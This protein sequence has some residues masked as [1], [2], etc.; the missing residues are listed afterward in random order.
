MIELMPSPTIPKAWVAP[1][2]IRDDDIGGVQVGPEAGRGLADDVRCVF[3]RAS[4]RSAADCGGCDAGA[5]SYGLQKAPAVERSP[6][7]DIRVH[8]PP[9]LL[10]PPLTPDSCVSRGDQDE[11]AYCLTGECYPASD[12]CPIEDAPVA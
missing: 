2:A 9:V 1:Q 4:R 8:L 3:A 11:R 6:I 7:R 12:R 5:P 10:H